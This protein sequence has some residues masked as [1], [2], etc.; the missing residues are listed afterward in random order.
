MGQKLSLKRMTS[1]GLFAA[2]LAVLSQI[3]ISYALRGSGDHADLC[4]SSGWVYS[5]MEGWPADCIYISSSGGC[6]PTCVRGIPWRNRK[7]GRTLR[8][9]SLGI[10]ASDRRLRRIIRERSG[11]VWRGRRRYR[12]DSMPRSG[13]PPVQRGGGSGACSV[14]SSGIGSVSD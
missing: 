8:G 7:P 3:Q 10:S 4:C 13:N 2:L 6:R 14:F 12:S 9:I 11:A 1:I 5:G